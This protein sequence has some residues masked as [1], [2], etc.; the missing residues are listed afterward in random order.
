MSVKSPTALSFSGCGFLGVY[1]I[2]AARCFQTHGKHILSNDLAESTR[3]LK[4]GALNPQF[5]LSQKV[6][7]MVDMVLP[8]DAHLTANGRVY[9]SVTRK[10]CG[11]NFVIS[12]FNSREDL[13]QV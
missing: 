13:I 4:M 12:S 1:H 8:S 11:K 6:E 7:Q 9:I 5:N 2:G 3:K 10:K